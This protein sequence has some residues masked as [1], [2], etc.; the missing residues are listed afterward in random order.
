MDAQ[1]AGFN[2]RF[3]GRQY[4]DNTRQIDALRRRGAAVV[5]LL[6]PES[7]ALRAMQPPVIAAAF[8]RALEAVAESSGPLRVIDLR[9][10]MPEELFVDY[11]HMNEAGRQA[12]SEKIPQLAQ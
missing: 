1:F 4:V 3:L 7:S 2:R 9:Q 10:A 11:G 8:N 6:M 12:L 5:C